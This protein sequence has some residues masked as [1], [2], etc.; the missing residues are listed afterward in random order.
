MNKKHAAQ[1]TR[2]L[3]TY[4]FP[5]MGQ[6]NVGDINQEHILAVMQPIWT[7][8]TETATRVRSRI[9][10]VLDWARVRGYRSGDNPEG[11]AL[12]SALFRT[13]RASIWFLL[14]CTASS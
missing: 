7:T 3:E 14:R 13:S 9:E 6:L 1:W 8:K 12:P 4:A 2:T 10:H 5:I 11:P